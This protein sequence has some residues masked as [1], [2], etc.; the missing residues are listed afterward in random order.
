LGQVRRFSEEDASRVSELHRQIFTDDATP[1]PDIY[2]EMFLRNPWF[3]PDISS[4]VYVDESGQVAGFLGVVPRII[5]FRQA[6]GQAAI[7]CQLMVSPDCRSSMAA[8]ILLKRH[9]SGPQ[10]MSVAD[11]VNES[12]RSVWAAMGAEYIPVYEFHWK[13]KLRPT[14]TRRILAGLYRRASARE[15]SESVLRRVDRVDRIIGRL[16]LQDDGAFEDQS[17]SIRAV[18]ASEIVAASEE[19][20]WRPTMF[21]YTPDSLEW[22]VK[23]ARPKHALGS[24]LCVKGVF[25]ADEEFVGLFAYFID[26]NCTAQVVHLGYSP[27][28]QNDVFCALLSAV[29]SEHAVGVIGRMNP[30]LPDSILQVPNLQYRRS[31]VGA[32]VHSKD[33]AL[34]SS[35]RS[36]ALVISQ[37]EGEWGINYRE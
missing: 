27:G 37:L 26:K 23:H 14:P 2:V 9:F 8:M 25:D 36:G 28:K 10:I 17:H 16:A 15:L 13:L 19:S 29:R 31:R 35:V 11:A 21:A 20:S 33:S 1:P 32:I 3:D 7:V 22:L 24:E 30:S 6:A 5:E 18:T 4:L 12:G 34:L